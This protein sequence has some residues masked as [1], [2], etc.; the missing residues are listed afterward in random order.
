M[1]PIIQTFYGAED[2]DLIITDGVAYQKDMTITASYDEDYLNK[3]AGY[4]GTDICDRIH[5]ARIS[6]VDKY[7]NREVL[8]IGIGSGE[9]IKRRPNTFGYDVNPQAVKWLK[10]KN[11]YRD[12]FETFSAFTMWDVLEHIENPHEYL[13][14]MRG[15]LFLSLPIFD[16]LDKVRESK[17]YRPG[18]HLYYFTHH[19]LIMWLYEYGFDLIESNDLE[20]QAGRE[21][22]KSYVF[23]V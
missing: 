6:L 9:F 19:G 23:S 5:S 14:K 12:D 20:T 8:D 21:S 11:L 7:Y 3:C 1:D 13:E 4:E 10:E 16:D 15:L 18:E 2:R 17:H 22:I